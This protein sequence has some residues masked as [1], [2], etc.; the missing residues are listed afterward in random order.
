MIA[1]T[2]RQLQRNTCS[3]CYRWL[4]GEGLGF[5]S[6]SIA[7]ILAGNAM[8]NIWREG[9][10]RTKCI[11]AN[12]I[13]ISIFIAMIAHH[14]SLEQTSSCHASHGTSQCHLITHA[15]STSEAPNQSGHF[16]TMQASLTGETTATRY[17]LVF[18]CRS[19]PGIL[20]PQGLAISRGGGG[21]MFQ[22]NLQLYT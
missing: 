19:G 15:S 14:A 12:I 3:F 7:Q 11:V 6:A 2:Q 10:F 21:H 8:G 18:N 17:K 16:G 22:T 5:H 9:P 4:F 13:L 1:L 20:V